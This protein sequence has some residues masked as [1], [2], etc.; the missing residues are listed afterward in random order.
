MTASL[1]AGLVL[2]LPAGFAPGPM[3]TLVITQTLKHGARE[4]LKIAMVP[5][6]SDT[7][8]IVTSLWILT[9]LGNARPVVGAIS[10]AGALFLIYLAIECLR[11]QR[12]ESSAGAAQPR[13]VGK[14]VVVNLLNPH[15]Y[16]FWFS[17]GSPILMKAWRAGVSDAA[18]FLAGFYFCLVGSKVLL[19]VL[20]G[21]GRN[22]L[23][24]GLYAWTMRVLGAALLV[25]AAL[26]GREGLTLLGV[27]V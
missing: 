16:L 13:S 18:A 3:L 19:A 6:L 2:G 12:I 8:I 11:T 10:L 4:G 23:T 27:A 17:V 20:T 5:L 14:G 21:R 25:F 1:L 9:R 26:F 22:L 15:P 24:G 7:P